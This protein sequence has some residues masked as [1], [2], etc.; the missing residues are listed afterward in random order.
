MDCDLAVEGHGFW[1]LIGENYLED[2][3]QP[4]SGLAKRAP[5]QFCYPSDDLQTDA[6]TVTAR[7]R[8][9]SPPQ[10]TWMAILDTNHIAAC[11]Y[12]DTSAR[13]RMT[14]GIFDKIA[15]GILQ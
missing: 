11:I 7:G 8:A 9:G 5:V 1:V 14:H 3:P 6:Q 4:G 2:V 12:D 15:Q 10:T 13:R